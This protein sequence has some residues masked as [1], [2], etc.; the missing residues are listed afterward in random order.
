MNPGEEAKA[1]MNPLL[2][3][4]KAVRKAWRE[5]RELAPAKVAI[6]SFPK[7]G[8]TWLRMLIGR[9]LCARYGLPEAQVLETFALTRA[10]GLPP[11]V[12]SHDGTS[13]TEG[14]PLSRLDRT[15]AAYRGK[16]VLLLCRDP[17]DTLIS[18]YFEATKRKR[19]YDGTLSEFLR[20][21]RYGIEKI[22]AF[23]ETWSDARGVP[24]ALLVV[25]Y[26][27][28]HADPGKV[29]RE[30]LAFLG[31]G[32]VPETVLR[33]AVEYGRFDNMRRIE[34]AGG[35][36]EGSRLRAADAADASSYKTRQGKV[37]GWAETLSPEDAAFANRALAA[38]RCPLLAAYRG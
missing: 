24:E 9:A 12:F 27:E 37:G 36:G 28:L 26:E 16:K 13:N 23:Y 35:L 8:R 17:R 4:A 21:P 29:L 3:R 6:V 11:T 22:V 38:S 33:D 31:A 25:S 19:V 30:T 10:A 18:C 20:D 32:D 7:S 15:K 5:R 14:R 2:R 34:Q 1:V